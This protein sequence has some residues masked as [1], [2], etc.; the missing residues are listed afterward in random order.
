M[1][2]KC[3]VILLLGVLSGSNC[4]LADMLVLEGGT[5]TT[6]GELFEDVSNQWATNHV[7]EIAELEIRARTDDPNHALNANSGYFGIN[8]NLAG[9]DYRAFDVGE[10]MFVSFDR[11]IQINFL[12]LNLFADG[13]VFGMKVGDSDP[14]VIAHR[15][16]S[17]GTSDLYTF[18]TPLTV[19]SDTVV[20]FYSV[21]G[22]M[23][24]DGIDLE[25]IPE[26]AVSGLIALSGIG[27]LIVRRF[28]GK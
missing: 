21:S 11:D 15:D 5:G 14:I 19:P 7:V 28:V 12:D 26:P 25:V 1:K 18:S 17:N 13:E 22:S 27:V 8:S 24:F 23:G 2:C 4:A 6:T 16:L 3:L 9:E 10:T 20:E